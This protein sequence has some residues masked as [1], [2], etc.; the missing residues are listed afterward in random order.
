MSELK[1]VYERLSLVQRDMAAVGVGKNGHNRD[2]N[3]KFRGI[4]DVYNTLAPILGRH[5]VL[6]IPTDIQ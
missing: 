4:D 6:I 1:L 2:Q 5:Q 3:F